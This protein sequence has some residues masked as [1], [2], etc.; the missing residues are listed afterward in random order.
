MKPLSQLFVFE[1]FIRL[2]VLLSQCSWWCHTMIISADKWRLCKTIGRLDA[3]FTQKIKSLSATKAIRMLQTSRIPKQKKYIMRIHY[4]DGN[5]SKLRSS[6]WNQYVTITIN[7][8]MICVAETTL[9]PFISAPPNIG[10][11]PIETSAHIDI[12]KPVHQW[13]R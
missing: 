2:F 5:Q 6:I 12:S 7:R 8:S 13:L 10:A 9:T 1:T 3:N 4:T 11:Y